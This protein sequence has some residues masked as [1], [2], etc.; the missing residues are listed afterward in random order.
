MLKHYVITRKLGEG[1]YGIV[2]EC[3]SRDHGSSQKFAIKV[4]KRKDPRTKQRFYREQEVMKTLGIPIYDI[5][6]DS[7]QVSFVMDKYQPN[8]LK[9]TMVQG[10]IPDYR[11]CFD[12]LLDCVE[13]LQQHHLVH[14]D[15]SMN[16]VA[17]NPQGK[18]TLIDFSDT[19]LVDPSEPFVK[20][21]KLSGTVPYFPFEKVFMRQ[22][23]P[24]SDLWSLGVLFYW[25]ET[26]KHPF[27]KTEHLMSPK[28]LV[29]S[30]QR[31]MLIT[32]IRDICPDESDESMYKFYSMLFS[33]EQHERPSIADLRLA[34]SLRTFPEPSKHSGGS[35]SEPSSISTCAAELPMTA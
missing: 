3:W 21:D 32:S 13:V 5:F 17:L 31:G 15:I 4:S 8:P 12:Q 1:S 27:L 28:E 25:A 22:A 29:G 23:W 30:L 16:N 34:L 33:V 24:T 14:N 6:E 11:S 18:L 9:K 2:H 7:E 26:G 20:L 19:L 10:P 35:G